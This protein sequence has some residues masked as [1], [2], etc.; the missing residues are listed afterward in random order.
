MR[1]AKVAGALEKPKDTIQIIP[2]IEQKRTEKR[3]N[4]RMGILSPV[5]AVS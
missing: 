1:Q 5:D 4:P 3:E 2:R